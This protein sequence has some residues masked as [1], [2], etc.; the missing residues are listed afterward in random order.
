MSEYRF[1]LIFIAFYWLILIFIDYEICYLFSIKCTIGIN[2]PFTE[3]YLPCFMFLH[4][5]C[6]KFVAFPQ[7]LTSL[8]ITKTFDCLWTRT[9]YQM[10]ISQYFL[11]SHGT[12]QNTGMSA[13]ELSWTHNMPMIYSASPRYH[14]W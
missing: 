5:E 14:T 4:I 2:K 6:L 9:W 7:L 12:D 11:Q 3:L 8:L 10:V 1:L 13:F